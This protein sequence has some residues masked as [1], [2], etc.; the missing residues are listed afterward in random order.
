[1]LTASQ[2]ADLREAL[3]PELGPKRAK[4]LAQSLRRKN[5]R[6]HHLIAA[7]RKRELLD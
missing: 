7:L 6:A 1:M 4:A 2:L 5:P 3:G